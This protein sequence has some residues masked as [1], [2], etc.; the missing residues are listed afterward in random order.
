M[1][2]AGVSLPK[3]FIN[4]FLEKRIPIFPVRMQAC[5]SYAAKQVVFYSSQSSFPN[6]LFSPV[7]VYANADVEKK[8]ILLENKNK[9]VVYR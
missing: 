6:S 4:S 8:K 9:A 7:K 5:G 1:K 2:T 3:Y